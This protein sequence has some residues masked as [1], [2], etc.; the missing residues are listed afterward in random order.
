MHF[1]GTDTRLVIR[2]ADGAPPAGGDL[3]IAGHCHLYSL[4]NWLWPVSR[5]PHGLI[6]HIWSWGSL[7]WLG[8]VVP[9]V[10]GLIGLLIFRHHSDLDT[11]QPIPHLV[12]WRIVSRGTNAEALTATIRA[13]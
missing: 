8:A 13:C 3:S 5:R 6:Q 11:V 2:L 10:C 12:V 7:T 4:Q 9:G 1:Q